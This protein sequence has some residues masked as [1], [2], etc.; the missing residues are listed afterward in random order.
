LKMAQYRVDDAP[1]SESA[2][3]WLN[4]LREEIP[5]MSLDQK[6]DLLEEEMYR[7][8]PSGCEETLRTLN[9]VTPYE[10]MT[11]LVDIMPLSQKMIEAAVAVHKSRLKLGI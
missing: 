5:T 1:D 6:L 2:N 7:E 11:R 9:L 4:T 3:D 8:D 10:T